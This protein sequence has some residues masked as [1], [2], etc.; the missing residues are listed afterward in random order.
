VWGERRETLFWGQKN[1]CS[2]D[3]RESESEEDL[4][5]CVERDRVIPA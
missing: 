4:E 3:A 5:F 2:F 1:T